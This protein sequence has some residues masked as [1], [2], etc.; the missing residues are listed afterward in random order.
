[1]NTLEQ[2]IEKLCPHGVKYLPLG[3]IGTIIRGNGLQK[4]ILLRKVLAVSIMVRFILFMELFAYE[5]KTFVSHE[6]ADKLKKVNKGDLIL[7]VTSEN[8]EDVCKCVAWLGDEEIVTGGHSAIVKH[9]QNP[10]FL[11]YFFQT[12][13]SFLKKEKLQMELRLL[14]FIQVN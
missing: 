11:S 14:R 8:V 2:L 5:T 9:N 1:M 7:A 10:K 13:T 12:K 3:E 4:K 6:L